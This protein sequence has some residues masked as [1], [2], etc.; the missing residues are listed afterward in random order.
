MKARPIRGLAGQRCTEARGKTKLMA[1]AH[2]KPNHDYHLVDPSP[3]PILG[4]IGAFI[5]AVGAIMWMKHIPVRRHEARQ[6]RLRRRLS[7]AF[8]T[9][10]PHGGRTSS[11]KRNIEGFHT[12]VV[13]ISHRYGMILFIALG[14]D[15]L[16]RLVLG[17]LRCEPL[18]GRADSIFARR[19]HRRA[20]AAEGHRSHRSLASSRCSTRSSC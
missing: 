5:M 18:S 4:A 17:L 1:D 11:R 14:S 7:L 3:W 12:R 16:R 8:S 15:V 10:W 9:S 13:Q 19:L 2:A 6:L 20:L